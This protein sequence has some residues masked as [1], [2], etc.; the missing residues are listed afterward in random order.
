VLKPLFRKCIS[1][2]NLILFASLALAS[3]YPGET[4]FGAE[5]ATPVSIRISNA[6]AG[7]L[8]LVTGTVKAPGQPVILVK[9]DLPNEPWWVQGQAVPAGPRGFSAKAVFGS[10]VTLPG[11]KFRVIAILTDPKLKQYVTGQVIQ[12]LPEVPMSDQLLITLVKSGTPPVAVIRAG[13]DEPEEQPRLAEIT[14]PKTSSSVPRVAELKGHIQTGYHPV[15]LVR[16]LADD[17]VWYV[18]RT[19]ELNENGE[20]TLK[21]VL[22]NSQTKQGQRFRIIVLAAP[23]KEAVSKLK[24]GTVV[25]KIPD[26]AGVSK[27]TVVTFREE[28]IEFVPESQAAR[29]ETSFVR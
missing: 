18:Q 17:S 15:V 1:S 27:E 24:V 3:A 14:S 19:P 20:F 23:S 13:S 28:V 4:A 21:A 7:R 10:A 9:P 8:Q 16:P 6:Q 22:G 29:F 25:R 11:T 26:G 2:Q 5:R 12:D